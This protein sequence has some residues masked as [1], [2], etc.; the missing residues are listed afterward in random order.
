MTKKFQHNN[1]HHHGMSINNE[2]IQI[3]ASHYHTKMLLHQLNRE[4]R[5]TLSQPQ[6][7]NSRH[8][9]YLICYLNHP[10][11]M[12]EVILIYSINN[13]LLTQEQMYRLCCYMHA[14]DV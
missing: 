9:L 13:S 8:S 12:F 11:N 1:N 10:L 7:K 2:M 6:I 3:F 14:W 4:N 5:V